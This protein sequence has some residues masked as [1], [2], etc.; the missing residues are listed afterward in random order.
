MKLIY[1]RNISIEALLWKNRAKSWPSASLPLQDAMQQ[2]KKLCF[3]DAK[4]TEVLLG[5]RR[6]S[7]CNVDKITYIIRIRQRCKPD[8]R[9]CQ[10]FSPSTSDASLRFYRHQIECV[11]EG[12]KGKQDI[13]W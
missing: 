3:A 8:I 4:V 1:F 13:G 11:G 10:K 2:N 7:I 12:I 5:D 9:K 6:R